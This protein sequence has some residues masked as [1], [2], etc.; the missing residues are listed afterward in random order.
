MLH[1][2]LGFFLVFFF[3][4][5][6]NFCD[7]PSYQC[8]R[9]C[10]KLSIQT[11]SLPSSLLI[12]TFH[13][14]HFDNFMMIS[15]TLKVPSKQTIIILSPEIH[16]LE[17]HEVPTVTTPVLTIS[18]WWSCQHLPNDPWCFV[19]PKLDFFP[20]ISLSALKFSVYVFYKK[21]D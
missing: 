19:P 18:F 7:L 20:I 11:I 5:I 12:T 9:Y 4:P 1:D 6:K 21:E 2:P 3:L 17:P 8:F 13:H 16:L 10:S 15:K 14:A